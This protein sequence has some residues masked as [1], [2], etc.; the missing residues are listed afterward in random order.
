[1]FT[2]RVVALRAYHIA[3]N[4]ISNM[5]RIVSAFIIFRF[6]FNF[7][8]AIILHFYSNLFAADS[9][10]QFLLFLKQFHIN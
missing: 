4:F 10:L 5:L 3:I 7:C 8:I 9:G 1:M 6:Y 2:L